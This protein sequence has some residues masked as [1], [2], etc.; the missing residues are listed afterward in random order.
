M[1]FSVVKISLF[2]DN[3]RRFIN[4]FKNKKLLRCV[5]PLY[6]YIYKNNFCRQLIHANKTIS[7]LSSISFYLF[8]RRVICE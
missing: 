6:M 1:L 3:V 8:F 5:K 4:T 2:T 7:F